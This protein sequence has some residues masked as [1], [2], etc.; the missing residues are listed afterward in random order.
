[1]GAII[2]PEELVAQAMDKTGLSD[3]GPDGWQVGLEQF[4]A[5]VRVDLGDDP[6]AAAAMQRQALRRLVTRLRI[7]GWYAEHGHEAAHPVEGPVVIV[8]LPRTATTALQYLLAID[9]QFR[10]Q[11]R[12][13]LSS[14]VPPPD[15]ATESED[16]RRAAGSGVA[17]AQHIATADG[18]I[19]DGPALALNFGN[20]DLALPL[21][22]YTKWWR[23]SDLTSTYAYHGRVHRLLH[24]HRPPYLWLLKAP[25]YLFHLGHLA[26]QYPNARFLWTHRDPEVAIPS[27]CSVVRTAREGFAPSHRDE[28]AELGAFILEH[29]VAGVRLATAARDSIGEGRFC[30][31]YQPDVESRP[32]AT[33]ERIYDFVGLELT[34]EVRAA[35]VAWTEE[36]RRGGRGEHRYAPED[37][38]LTSAGIHEAFGGYLERFGDVAGSI[39]QQ[40]G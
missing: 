2:V 27:T 40:V 17:S 15:L 22:T 3:L 28:P 36:N 34:D 18:P 21:P 29:F 13:E 8:G 11:R 9:P 16:P 7:E 32:M 19:E 37:Y 4:L 35:M 6:V 39:G 38:G 23:T 10:Y 25:G 26:K 20:Q 5:A 33:V 14:P 12:W 31:V 30:D 24:S 1:M